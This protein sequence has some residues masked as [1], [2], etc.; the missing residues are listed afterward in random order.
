M[1][2]H[3]MTPENFKEFDRAAKYDDYAEF[4]DYENMSWDWNEYISEALAE[5]CDDSYDLLMRTYFQ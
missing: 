2:N 4:I 3:L 5:S 1:H